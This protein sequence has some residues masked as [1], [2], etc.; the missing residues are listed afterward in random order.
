VSGFQL[1]RSYGLDEYDAHC[2]A[3]GLTLEARYATWDQAPF[4]GDVS[5][6]VS[7]SRRTVPA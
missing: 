1:Q 7:V 4:P 5:Y 6:A 3:A 2:A